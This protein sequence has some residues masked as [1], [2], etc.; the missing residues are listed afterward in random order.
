VTLTGRITLVTGAARRIGLYA[1]MV[2]EG[3]YRWRKFLHQVPFSEEAELWEDR[4]PPSERLPVLNGGPS[5]PK[6]A[7]LDDDIPFV[8][9]WGHAIEIKL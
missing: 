9:L 2:C 6:T 5:R 1:R 8:A 4:D 7:G 3:A